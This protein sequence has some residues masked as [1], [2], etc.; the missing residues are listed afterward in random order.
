[1]NELKELEVDEVSLVDAGANPQAHI[2][3][4]KRKQEEE[5]MA[6]KD[7]AVEAVEKQEEVLTEVSQP[8]EVAKALEQ[9]LDES[10]IKAENAKLQK[11]VAELEEQIAAREAAEKAEV[12]KAA[13]EKA[14]ADNAE[15]VAT[16]ERLNKRMEEHIEKAEDAELMKVAAKYE[17][18]G[19]NAENTFKLLKS[20]KGTEGYDLLIGTFDKALAQVEKSG[21]FDEIGKRGRNSAS[22]SVEEMAKRFQEQDASLSW[23]E[24]LEKAYASGAM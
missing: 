14:A 6:K 2:V 11:R 13:A 17:V 12:D 3:F 16:L 21:L 19:E 8:N 7:V 22:G 10:I 1:M 4:F 20:L 15:L 9:A 24:A 23:R 18:L 5:L